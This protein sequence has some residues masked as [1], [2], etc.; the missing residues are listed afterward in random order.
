M[1]KTEHQ[2]GVS[3]PEELRQQFSGLERR[4]W[5]AETTV[6]VCFALS[7][8]LGSYLILFISDRI[9]DTPVFLRVIIAIFGA[10]ASAFAGYWWARRWVFRRRDIRAL[11]NLVQLRFRRLGD[12]LLGIVE[13][14][15][16]ENRPPGFSPALYRA[17]I[18]QVSEEAKQFDFLDAVNPRPVK[19]NLSTVVCLGMLFLLPALLVPGAAWNVFLRWVA[20]AGAIERYTLVTI[21]DLPAQKVVPHGEAFEVSASVAY[22]SFWK[23]R[24][25]IAEYADQ[26][27]VKGVVENGMVRLTIPGQIEAD[28]LRLRI[29]D[30]ARE[31]SILPT[32]RPSLKDMTAVVELPEY[33]RHPPFTE[34]VKNG[35]LTVLEGSKVSVSMT[36][37]RS[38][39]KAW[40]VS[41]GRE[42]HDL[43]VEGETFS[44]AAFEMDQLMHQT[45]FWEDVLGLTNAV[46]WELVVGTERDFPPVPELQDFARDLAVLE[47]EVV[48]LKAGARDD[49]GVR[50]IGLRW[51]FLGD[52][53][54]T[55]NSV[56]S[57]FRSEA[58]SSQEKRFEERFY[59]NPA[60]LGIPA[61]SSVELRT[62]ATDFFPGREPVES[63]LYRVFVLGTEQH[64]EMIR[65]KLESML[66]R[67]EEVTRLEE[68]IA[69]T[70]S[71]LKELSK[72]DLS[73][74]EASEALD[75]AADEQA[76]NARDLERLAEEGT[77][78]VREGM[79]NPTLPNDKLQEWAENSQ[80]MQ[81]LAEGKMQE[82]ANDLKSAK[83]NQESK[84][85]NLASAQSKTEEI[86]EDLQEMQRLFNKGLDDLQAL[87][88]AQ[89]LRKAATEE[90]E[91][92]GQL[93]KQV[94][95]T[96]GLLADELPEKYQKINADL[97]ED[98]GGA[99]RDS[100]VLRGEISRFFERTQQP[101]YGQ[102]SKEMKEAKTAEE[103]DRVGGLIAENISMQAIEELSN[104]SRRF[105]AWA[106]ILEPKSDSSGGGGGGGGGE[107]QQAEMLLKQLMALLRMREGEVNL[108]A[109]TSLLEP[110]KDERL[111]YETGTEMLYGEQR[112]LLKKLVQMQMD[113]LL[114]PLIGPLQEIYR[115]MLESSMLL[116][117]PR[118]DQPTIQAETKTIEVLSDVIN[119]INE[120]SQKGQNSQSQASEQMAFLLRMMS[121]QQGESMGM[122]MSNTAG[123]NPTGGATDQAAGSA[124]GDASGK[125]SGE[126]DVGKASG[127]ATQNV[128]VE[129]R[130]ALENYFKLIEETR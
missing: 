37:T 42:Y 8:L 60:L 45:F 95:E 66:V 86:L 125:E 117:E 17:A 70:L 46:P 73:D 25:V 106:D 90:K 91:I 113:N 54:E 33:L 36:A 88:L 75:E 115:P 129:F 68:K 103:L 38:L 16:E 23:P 108:R 58:E 26:A 2:L 56:N 119:L 6:A 61:D 43:S 34:S 112:L 53:E 69:A 12:R 118:T 71:Q 94:P 110:Q 98:Q 31:V 78:T 14:A 76:R 9:W 92:E 127:S 111:A 51:R 41:D 30:V 49:Y 7:G 59:F 89:R 27:G 85:E 11:S 104:W 28:R 20:P 5:K 79:R 99:Q 77:D 50:E 18:A 83:S 124:E 19:V 21:G 130:E 48:E 74:E 57:N 100:E 52:A 93:E 3:L 4:L 40:R 1:D 120:Q 128:P 24:I 123:G 65:Q 82:A 121:Q 10:V 44:T 80:A 47:T 72:Q 122:A 29:G 55:G 102:V 87:T 64:A 105:T 62:Y 32:H 96:I 22:G 114:P 35:S 67:L 107:N 84:Q 15:N 116:G 63:H 126:K 101:N 97:A 109:R 39:K 81:K 13:L